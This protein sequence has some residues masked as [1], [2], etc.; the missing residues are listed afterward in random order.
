MSNKRIVTW[1]LKIRFQL[2]L[3]L[4]FMNAYYLQFD[5]VN[6]TWLQNVTFLLPDHTFRKTFF[7]CKRSST[8]LLFHRGD[9]SMNHCQGFLLKRKWLLCVTIAEKRIKIIHRYWLW[10]NYFLLCNKI[11]FLNG[12]CKMFK[13]SKQ[14]SSSNF[15]VSI[16]CCYYCNFVMNCSCSLF[17]FA[18]FFASLSWFVFLCFWLSSYLYFFLV[19][20]CALQDLFLVTYIHKPLGNHSCWFPVS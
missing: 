11:I 1:S 15:I 3:V 6:S 7:R 20:L 17:F 12:N 8:E 9:C 2:H 5:S 13:K 14:I 16:S 10:S 4:L 19:K 18:F